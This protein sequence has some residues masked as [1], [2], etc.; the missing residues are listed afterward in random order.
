M[1]DSFNLARHVARLISLLGHSPDAVDQ[2]KLELRT[3]VLL[4]KEGTLRLSTRGGQL[5]ANGLAV[6]QVL[7]GVRD[8]ADRM[9][10]HGIESIEIS[11]GMAPGEFLAVARILGAPLATEQKVMRERLRALDAQTVAVTLADLGAADVAATGAAAVPAEPA[12]GTAGRIPFVLARA[13]RG[14]EGMPLVPHFDEV[15]F[16]V[17]QSTRE[18]RIADAIDTFAQIVAREPDASDPEVR[19]QF[20]LTVRRLTKPHLLYAVARALI[21]RRDLADA[22]LAVLSRC[23]SDGADAVVDVFARARTA[24]ERAAAGAVLGRLSVADE[25]LMAMLSDVRPHMARVAADL[26]GERRPREGDRALADKLS[27]ADP[28]VRRAFVRA[29]GRYESPFAMDAV[30]RGLDDPVVEVRLEAVAALARRKGARVG[31]II[32]RAVEKEADLEVQVGLITALGRIGTAD[33]VTKLARV[34]EA[35]SGL[36]GGRKDA[37]VRVAAARALAEART[38]GAISVLTGLVN[39]KDREVRDVAARAVVR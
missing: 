31:D 38:P 32:G 17:E 3:I 21:D 6:P 24:A 34:A 36:F 4:A 26:I 1:D 28:R 8:L 11:Q 22:A 9:D 7:P 18:G 12:P 16:A 30:A 29:L 19:R 35:T 33:A 20:V 10:G 39:D 37:A 2:H 15:A 13:A 25:A 14:G 23:G 27:D 5:M